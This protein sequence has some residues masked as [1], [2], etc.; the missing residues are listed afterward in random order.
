M[1][2][3]P[4][5]DPLHLVRLALQQGVR[6]VLVGEQRPVRDLS[7]P[8]DGDPGLFGPESATWRVHQD[9]SMLIGGVRALLYQTVH[10]LAMAGVAQ[11]SSYRSDP[12]GRLRRTSTFV[13]LTTFGTTAE[14]Q[15]AIRTVRKVHDRVQGTAPDGR[16]YRANDP[17]LLAWV[18]HTEVDSFLRAYQ[19]YGPERLNDGDADRYVA[20]MAELA[21][22]LGATGVATSV[23]ELRTW[24]HDIR[25]EL[26]GGASARDAARFLLFPPLAPMLRGA[27]AILAA[28][29][30]GLL[31]S[32]VRR[33][34]WIPNLPVTN[35]LAVRP[36][37]TVL[38]KALAW[39]MSAP[40][41]TP[42]PRH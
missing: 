30:V 10:P 1:A 35:A 21:R 38:T 29:A 36:A 7:R 9:S 26:S 22:R 32:H 5:V 41:R 4:L 27:Y 17:H 34:L 12:M 20:E 11:H 24:M 37:A 15:R 40:A 39:V 16:E 18:H 31:P 19:R 33:M 25:P 2:R 14:A 42:P 6:S 23:G 8:V 3:S 28:S 13:G